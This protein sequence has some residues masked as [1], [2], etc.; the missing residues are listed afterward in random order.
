MRWETLIMLALKIQWCMHIS[1][2]IQDLWL[3]W[4]MGIC[5]RGHTTATVKSIKESF[6]LKIRPSFDWLCSWIEAGDWSKEPIFKFFA[7]FLNWSYCNF[8]PFEPF[9][10]EKPKSKKSC[11][12]GFQQFVLKARSCVIKPKSRKGC[13]EFLTSIYGF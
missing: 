5:E 2:Q 1:R 12:D 11:L 13:T 8:K 4:L 9:Y 10:M 3:R 6:M 7:G